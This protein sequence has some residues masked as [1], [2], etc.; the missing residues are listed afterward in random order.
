MTKKKI[1]LI[2]VILAI[3][4]S[5]FL[6]EIL[7]NRLNKQL[8]GYVNTESTRL[9]SNIV[10]YSVNET[11]EKNINTELFK[12]TK[13][14]QDEVEILDY[15]TKEVNRILKAINQS[16]QEKLLLLEEGNIDEFVIAETFKNGK[17]KAVKSGIICEI[18]MGTLKKNAFFSNF[19]PNIP[20][21]MTF[22][23]SINSN[24][25]TKVTPYGFNSLVVETTIHIE[26][27]TRISIPTSSKQNK[28]VID[29]PLTMKV[30]QGFIPE[31]YYI[32]G[33]E[34]GSTEYIT[35]ND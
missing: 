22:L 19:G 3:I 14:K 26:I 23:G 5:F 32:K 7:G 21:K 28:I 12:I 1:F 2:I 31:Y 35:E 20:I 24:L 10:N 29:A 4:S 27:A 8:Y 11:L 30:I 13:N 15:N 16:I 17:F 25:N 34:K 18:P 9:A 6:L 33:L